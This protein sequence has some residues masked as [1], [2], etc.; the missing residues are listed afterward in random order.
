MKC[1]T[2]G[3]HAHPTK[4]AAVAQLISLKREGAAPDLG[5]YQCGAFWHVG[6]NAVAFRKR[7]QKALA[8]GRSRDSIYRRRGKK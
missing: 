8:P 3:K 2:C 5:V 6:H 4:G 7:I 1:P